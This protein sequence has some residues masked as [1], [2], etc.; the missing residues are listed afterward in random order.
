MSYAGNNSS[1]KP[2]PFLDWHR[3]KF[4]PLYAIPQVIRWAIF[5]ILWTYGFGIIWIPVWYFLEQASGNGLV[6][7]IKSILKSIPFNQCPSCKENWVKELAQKTLIGREKALR[8]VTRVDKHYT[9]GDGA[10]FT[11]QVGETVREEQIVSTLE[12]YVLTHRCKSCGHTWTETIHQ[13]T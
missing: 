3:R 5:V 4:S 2:E 8:T 6:S 10:S 9:R 7:K 1:Q 12:T 13:Y 11:K